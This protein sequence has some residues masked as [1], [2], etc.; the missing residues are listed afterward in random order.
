MSTTTTYE[1]ASDVFRLSIYV[2][3]FDMQ[4]NHFLVRDEEPQKSVHAI[5]HESSHGTLS[6]ALD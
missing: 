4:F 2:P 6:T 3:E 5:P 1:I